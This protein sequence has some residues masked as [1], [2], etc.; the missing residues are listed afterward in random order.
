MASTTEV[1]TVTD[2][3]KATYV[4]VNQSY[5]TGVRKVSVGLLR[6]CVFKSL[7]PVLWVGVGRTNL[8]TSQRG[9]AAAALGGTAPGRRCRILLLGDGGGGR[10]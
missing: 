6:P 9:S 8:P 5:S 7:P 4:A 2:H 10:A 1:P 3:S